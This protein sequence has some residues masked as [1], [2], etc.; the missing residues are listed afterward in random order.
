MNRPYRLAALAAFML[1]PFAAQADWFYTLVRYECVPSEGRI[2]VSYVGAYNAAGEAMVANKSAN[3]WD[4]WKLVEIKDDDVH[5][6]IVATHP[7][8][9]VC[10]LR[11]GEYTVVIRP[12][13]GNYNVQGRCGAHMSAG[14]RVTRA[15]QVILDTDFEGDCH[16]TTPV[17]TKIVVGG[18]AK[19]TVITKTLWNEFY[20]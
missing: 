12:V 7:V 9:Q 16:D 3:E 18:D 6:R 4:P 1:I 8:T 14:V 10:L 11:D 20:Q 17:V 13:P 2:V 5:T 15:G 19:E